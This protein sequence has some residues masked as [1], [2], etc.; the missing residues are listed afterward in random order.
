M[1]KRLDFYSLQV[2][3][4][5]PYQYTILPHG[6]HENITFHSALKIKLNKPFAV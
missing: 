3:E 2:S 6:K 4:R 5:K 1:Q